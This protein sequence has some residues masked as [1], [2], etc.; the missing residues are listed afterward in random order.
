MPVLF[1]RAHEATKRLLRRCGLRVVKVEGCCGALHAHNGHLE[2]GRA[3]ASKLPANLPL[4]VD[5]AGC[6]SWLK[7]S[8]PVRKVMDVTEALASHGLAEL[9]QGGQP[10]EVTATYHDACHLAHGQKIRSQPRS[11]L[12][13][14]PGLRLVEL[15]ESDTCCGSAGIYNLTQ[16]TM[17]KRLLDRKWR[18]IETTGAEIVV[19]GNPGCQAWIQQ[20]ANEHGR[21]VRVMHTVELLESAF[22]GLPP[23]E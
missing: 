6:G 3:L 18:H 17:A 12:A 7:G 5:A 19:S 20:A 9:L 11:L 1:A 14:I 13:A 10:L 21:H 15:T 16:P 22:S 23:A 8:F 4:V 2:E